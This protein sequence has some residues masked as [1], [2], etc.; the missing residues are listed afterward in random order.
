M[1][2]MRGAVFSPPFLTTSMVFGVYVWIIRQLQGMP[3]KFT[4]SNLAEHHAT[5]DSRFDAAVRRLAPI[6]NQ[7]RE[8]T[9]SRSTRKLADR[10]NEMGKTGPNGKSLSY[11][12]MR[13][14]LER[15]RWRFSWECPHVT[16]GIGSAQR[17][18]ESTRR[19]RAGPVGT[20]SRPVE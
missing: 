1:V 20:T 3:V 6:I 19:G 10:L 4:G 8:K 2:Q 13:R 11:G 15:M 7:L 16:R 14:I 12:T 5:T 18:G 17:S 9:D